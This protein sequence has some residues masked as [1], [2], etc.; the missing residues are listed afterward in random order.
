MLQFSPH[1]QEMVVVR[2]DEPGLS[3]PTKEK[4]ATASKPDGRGSGSDSCGCI[5]AVG[6]KVNPREVVLEQ[7]LA[8]P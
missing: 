8:R 3:L 6:E 7:G 4:K 1:S 2:K 5:R